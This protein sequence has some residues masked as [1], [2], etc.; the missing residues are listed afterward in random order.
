[1]EYASEVWDNCGQINSDRL[2]KVQIEAKLAARVVTGF[3][4]HLQSLLNTISKCLCVC[5]GSIVVW[6]K[7]N[8]KLHSTP[9][10]LLKCGI[11]VDK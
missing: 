7:L 5:T 9:L 4:V 11:I 8:V 3:L 2:E 6:S 10:T 1:L